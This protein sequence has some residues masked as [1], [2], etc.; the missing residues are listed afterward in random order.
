MTDAGFLPLLIFLRLHD[1][2]PDEH[3]ISTDTVPP[4]YVGD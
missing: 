2:L 1:Q 4:G 3:E